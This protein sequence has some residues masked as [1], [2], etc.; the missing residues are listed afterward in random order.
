MAPRKSR[1]YSMRFIFVLLCQ[2][3][4][5]AERNEEP[6]MSCNSNFEIYIFVAKKLF[7]V[8]AKQSDRIVHIN[9]L[10]KYEYKKQKLNRGK[11]Q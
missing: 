7:T 11:Y 4:R 3:G 2:R 5:S 6:L 1:S 8:C 9:I 10:N